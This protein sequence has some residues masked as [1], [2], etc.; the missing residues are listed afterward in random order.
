[1]TFQNHPVAYF[2]V[3]FSHLSFFLSSVQQVIQG[4]SHH[5]TSLPPW[6]ASSWRD[7]GAL[8]FGCAAAR[9]L[10][11]SSLEVSIPRHSAFPSGLSITKCKLVS[12]C[13]GAPCRGKGNREAEFCLISVP[14]NTGTENSAPRTS[15]LT[16]KQR[17]KEDGEG[18][19]FSSAC[20][21]WATC[22]PSRKSKRESMIR[23]WKP[24]PQVLW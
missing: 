5:T 9:R 23:L 19:R 15:A 11:R 4:N 3:I 14:L 2:L 12:Q 16:F 22:N 20:R 7:T 17:K 13:W 8:C 1:M 21:F 18:G 10:W 6:R 24:L